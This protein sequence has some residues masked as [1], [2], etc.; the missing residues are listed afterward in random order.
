MGYSDNDIKGFILMIEYPGCSKRVGY[1]EKCT[2]GEFLNYPAI[3]KPVF[4]KRYLRDVKIK[5]ILNKKN[6]Q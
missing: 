1:Y 3:W 4:K 5:E 6:P 2:S